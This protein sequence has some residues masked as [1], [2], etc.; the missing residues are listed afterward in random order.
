MWFRC[1]RAGAYRRE[2]LAARFGDAA[3]PD[4]IITLTACPRRGD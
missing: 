3:L 2:T 1:G 4:V